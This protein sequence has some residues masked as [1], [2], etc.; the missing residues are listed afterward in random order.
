ML[1]VRVAVWWIRR[2]DWESGGQI[3]AGL[4]SRSIEPLSPADALRFMFTLDA[5][6]YSLEG[7]KAVAYDDG[8]HTKHR[9]MRYQD[10]FVERVRSGERVLDI[11]CGTG[12][13]AVK[14]AA[15]AGGDVVGVDKNEEYLSQARERNSHPR[16]KY[17][18]GDVLE[19]LPEGH[20]DVAILSNVLEHL[21]DRA[22]F[23]KKVQ[24]HIN[25]DRFLIRVPLFEREWR[26][27]LRQ[28]LGVEWRLDLTHETEYT[29]ESFK[30]EMDAA[31][32]EIQFLEVRWGEIWA[33]VLTR[34][35]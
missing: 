23:L 11:G 35:A 6:L 34:N 20:F 18:A 33:E 16:V 8:V 1:V 29:L 5:R 25:P 31:G 2:Q 21:P 14:V 22:E 10:F 15:L 17:I 27:P 4:V 19:Y 3:A 24:N 7:A 9:H 13:I 26:V 28:E 30:E 32:L 12:A